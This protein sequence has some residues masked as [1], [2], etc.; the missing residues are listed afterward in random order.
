MS[1]MPMGGTLRITTWNL[2][3]GGTDGADDSRLRG[4]LNRITAV[5]PHDVVFL[6][7]CKWGGG[8]ASSRRLHQVARHLNMPGG[9]YLV[10][11]PRYGCDLAV[12]V[13]ETST[14]RVVQERHETGHAPWFH[15]LARVEVAVGAA[16]GKARRIDLCGV[17]LAPSAPRIRADEAEMFNLLGKVEAI[18]AGDFNARALDERDLPEDT[19][20]SN[21]KI[22]RK[23]DTTPAQIIAAAGFTDLGEMA[24]DLTPTVGFGIGPVPHRADRIHT[25]IN[26]VQVLEHAVLSA[27][28]G[29]RRLS[30]HDGVTALIR[31]PV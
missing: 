31:V 27:D 2:H 19:D 16:T 8:G 17:H 20:L 23:L 5:G 14:L 29:A 15:A 24:G 18:A 7:E 1:D 12:L 25:N 6:Q 3:N 30:D 21:A 11:A 13:R 26:G 28:D 10:P 22:S 4:I 9:R